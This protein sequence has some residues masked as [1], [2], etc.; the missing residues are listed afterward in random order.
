[1]FIDDMY[2]SAVSI[3]DNTSIGLRTSIIAHLHWGP[4]RDI[5]TIRPLV[6]GA[7]VFVGPHC[8]ILPGVTIGDGSVVQAGTV[9]SRSIP[10][11]TFWG[12]PMAGPIAHVSVPLTHEHTHAEFVSGL[13]RF[14]SGNRHS[15]TTP[16]STATGDAHG[17]K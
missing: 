1:V 5:G 6:I 7:D 15:S 16:S 11:H 14:P 13:R 2:P 9:V 8:V 10:P 4:E 17:S 3:G 12:A